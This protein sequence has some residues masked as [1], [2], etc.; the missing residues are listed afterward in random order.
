MRSTQIGRLG[1]LVVLMTAL[2]SMAGCQDADAFVLAEDGKTTYTIVIGAEASEAE[3][4]AAKEL[5]HFLK[6]MTGAEFA[7]K[8]DDAGASDFEIVLGNTN[9]KSLGELGPELRPKAWEGFA[10]FAEGAKL[11]IMGNIPRATLYGVYDFLEQELGVRFVA[12]KLTHVPGRAVLKVRIT[13]RRFDPVLE[14]R[15]LDGV[16]D[17]VWAVRN[18]LNAHGQSIP[19]ERMLGGVRYAGYPWHTF[20]VLVS[21]DKYFKDHPEYFAMKNGKRISKR[22]QLCLTNPEVF[23]IAIK[24]LRGWIQNQTK[25]NSYNPDTLL[26]VS[27]TQN[28]WRNW[29]EC[30]K[31]K[32]IDDKEGGPSGSY[33]SFVNKVAEALE[34]DFPNVAVVMFGYMYTQDPPKT[35]RPRDNVIVMFAN[36]AAIREPL[37]FKHPRRVRELTQIR[38]WGKATKRLYTW[39]YITNFG[40][41]VDPC[42]SLWAQDDNMRT[43]VANNL[44]GYFG[45]SSQAKHAELFDL[46]MY[47]A[48][49]C[50]WRPET[51]GRKTIE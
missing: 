30:P 25:S 24:T 13:P 33:M 11:Y 9:R 31:C 35:I 21:V 49:Q 47:L 20:E 48:A 28:D 19:F 16:N 14:Y 37:G 2:V 10:I 3:Q 27:V 50:A 34:D 36:H 26:M 22:T 42:A 1:I 44:K 8:L 6:E 7:T 18:R 12:P 41:F 29:C 15:S 5:A 40:A 23:E 51:D 39:D 38:R 32:A 46:R 43:L 45:Q 17:G 4:Y